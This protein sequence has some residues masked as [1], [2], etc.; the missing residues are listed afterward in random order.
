MTR[1]TAFIAVFFAL[2]VCSGVLA[3]DRS[4]VSLQWRAPAGCPSTDAVQ[5]GLREHRGPGDRWNALDAQAVVTPHGQGYELVLKLTTDDDVIRRR[6]RDPDCSVLA[7][8][9]ALL[10]ALAARPSSSTDASGELGEGS[11]PAGKR[12]RPVRDNQN[13]DWQVRLIAGAWVRRGASVV[14]SP[15]VQAGAELWH[16]DIGGG[17][18]F[19]YLRASGWRPPTHPSAELRTELW[20]IAATGCYRQ[21]ILKRLSVQPCAVIEVG[22]LIAK[23]RSIRWPGDTELGWLAGGGILKARMQLEARIGIFVT[24]AL[25]VPRTRHRF[26][27]R[28]T[29]GDVQLHRIAPLSLRAGIGLDYSF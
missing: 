2:A 20:S 16:G 5:A 7:D 12:A 9:A 17:L 25:L 24:G 22:R 23:V 14:V 18:Q 13:R 10:I 28:T 26:F 11:P 19:D 29:S 1:R 8:G 15:G 4:P 3:E 27:I 6:L 21:R